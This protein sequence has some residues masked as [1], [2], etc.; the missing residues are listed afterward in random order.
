[1]L[2]DVSVLLSD[3]YNLI[4]ATLWDQKKALG[5]AKNTIVYVRGTIQKGFRT[6]INFN[7]S[8]MEKIQ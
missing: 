6:T 2:L 7:V 5:W 4:E 1:M 3:G 8:E